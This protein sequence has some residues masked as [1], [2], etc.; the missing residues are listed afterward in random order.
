METSFILKESDLNTDFLEALKVLFKN[1]KQLEIKVSVPEDFNLLETETPQQ[2]KERL[3]N[4]L[5]DMGDNSKIIEFTDSR[6][7]LE[8]FIREKT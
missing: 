2:I 1:K 6:L 5:K 8:E 7:E 3:Q 4:C